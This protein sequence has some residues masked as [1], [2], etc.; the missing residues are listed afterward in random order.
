MKRLSFLVVCLIVVS[1]KTYAVTDF[2]TPACKALIDVVQNQQSDEYHGL[3]LDQFI[4]NRN[5]ANLYTWNSENYSL[6]KLHSLESA[7]NVLTATVVGAAI[8]KGDLKID[9]RL[10]DFFPKVI[11]DPVKQF[12][13][14]QITIDHLLSMSSGL[15]WEDSIKN[16]LAESTLSKMLF[17]D[18]ATDM[19]QFVLDQ[20]ME[21]LPGM[22]W[23]Y[24][25]GHS[26]VL[27][28]ILKKLYGHDHF[29]D[30]LLFKPLGI[31]KAFIE[32][33]ANGNLIGSNY[34]FMTPE[35]MTKIGLLYLN[36][37]M[38]DK[39]QILP[40]AWVRKAQV[41]ADSLV[42][43]DNH[44][45]S[46]YAQARGDFSQRGFWLN[47][48]LKTLNIAHQFPHSPSDMYFAAGDYGQMIIILPTQNLVIT[49]TGHN[50]EFRS[51]IDKLVSNV[52]ACF[53][54]VPLLAD[55]VKDLSLKPKEIAKAEAREE[56]KF[57]EAI[58]DETKIGV[59]AI[60]KGYFQARLSQYV[61]HCH[62]VT[63]LSTE[64]CM[65]QVSSSAT[66]LSANKSIKYNIDENTQSVTVKPKFI[67]AAVSIGKAKAREAHFTIGS[68]CSVL[69]E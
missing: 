19:N 45:D 67:S 41:S 55:P 40:K 22:K 62:Y 15:K 52:T 4:V 26:I 63:E 2:S 11:K 7:S 29:I 37:G 36:E 44:T 48:D 47:Q 51:K 34:A 58:D 24:N 13:Y 38:V 17:D 12:Y 53:S 66:T 69:P 61:C 56:N 25:G 65:E 31:K 49:T 50:R 20:E 3:K 9:A 64:Q 54:G 18:Q 1:H 39:I 46:K 68:G 10:K 23:N 43:T 27:L 42:R 5:G 16:T 14:D 28:A 8:Q 33:D 59:G 60:A 6:D 30:D 57:E 35:E 21:I 32:K